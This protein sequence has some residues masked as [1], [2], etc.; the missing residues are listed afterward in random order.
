MRGSKPFYESF[1]DGLAAVN[2]KLE[3]I[4]K[5]SSNNYKLQSR[6]HKTVVLQRLTNI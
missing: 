1:E 4:H 2:H 3:R 5:K 6:A